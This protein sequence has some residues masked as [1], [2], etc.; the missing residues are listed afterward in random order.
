MLIFLFTMMFFVCVTR[1]IVC[2]I[3]YFMVFYGLGLDCL[4]LFVLSYREVEIVLGV[5][6]WL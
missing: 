1:L 4:F 6:V 2:W 3:G 5:C